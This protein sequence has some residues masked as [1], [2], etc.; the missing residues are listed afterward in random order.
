MSLPPP[1][2]KDNAKKMANVEQSAAGI[3]S[4]QNHLGP[5]WFDADVLANVAPYNNSQADIPNN[6]F[7]VGQYLPTN[8]D[9]DRRLQMWFA[10]PSA[11]DNGNQEWGVK[12]QPTD[13]LLDYNELKNKEAQYRAELDLA[14]QLIDPKDPSS[15]RAAFA[16][17][18]ELRDIPEERSMKI[19]KF[20][21]ML[22]AILRAGTCSS[23]EEV[24]MIFV[25]LDPRTVIPM[26]PGWTQLF[27]L[28]ETGAP[29]TSANERF[30]N[31]FAYWWFNP[32]YYQ[33]N[34]KV[35]MVQKLDAK[36]DYSLIGTDIEQGRIKVAIARR[37][38]P[39]L[40][41]ADEGSVIQF[42]L[43][44]AQRTASATPDG[45]GSGNASAV[46][47]TKEMAPL[48]QRGR[49]NAPPTMGIFDANP[50]KT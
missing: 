12:T 36:P 39:A 21:V 4:K 31:T 26:S 11:T 1:N 22:E 44:L 38:F 27:A 8:Q 19:A 2:D 34:T 25:L 40:R 14:A 6:A 20:H 32:Y 23:R 28:D 16:M 3:K 41:V 49:I 15:Q 50:G 9:L 45:W 35:A 42:I 13:M 17:Y 33:E 10:L 24:Q 30:K 46:L 18:P 48:M 7:L 47:R 37:L 29:R 5:A 43:N